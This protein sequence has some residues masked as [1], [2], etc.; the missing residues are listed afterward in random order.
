[1]NYLQTTAAIIIMR[2]EMILAVMGIDRSLDDFP[3]LATFSSMVDEKDLD[4]WA[5]M[6]GS[7][8]SEGYHKLLKL[9]D[10]DSVLRSLLDLSIAVFCYPETDAYFVRY[11]GHGV[12]LR[13]AFLMEGIVSPSEKD[14][15]DKAEKASGIFS[16]DDKAYPLSYAPVSIDEKTAFFL[17]GEKRINP[18][19][20][21]VTDY[22]SAGKEGA[23]VY[24]NEG[25]IEEGT[26]FF[27]EGGLYL[28]LSGKGGRRFIAKRIADDLNKDFLFINTGD[29]IKEAG[30]DLFR[31]Y[32]DCLIREAILDEAG[33][34]FFGID[35]P[36][37][38]LERTLF[39]PVSSK[40]IPIILCADCRRAVLK[41]KDKGEYRNLR[42]PDEL[43]LD[44]RKKLWEEL[45]KDKEYGLDPYELALKYRLN[46][47][48][49]ARVA[50]SF[51][52]MRG[53]GD[54]TEDPQELL[55]RVSIEE[56]S[57]GEEAGYGRVVY[58]DIRLQDV[59]VKD[60][61]K[62]TLNEVVTSVRTS[63][64]ILDKWGLKKT[65]PY[66]RSVSL[67]ISGPPGTGKTMTANAIAGELSLGLYQ[68]NLSNIIDKFI[69]ETEK[70]LEKVFSYAEKSN[71]VLFFDEADSLFGTRSEVH[72][73]KDRYA[74]TEISYLLQRIEA[75]E[76]IV[77]M[78]TNIKGNID[79]AFMRRI[80]YV[81]HFENPD[82]E[83]RKE[84]W[85][86]LFTGEVPHEE[87]DFQYL[88][89]QFDDFT[90][91]VIKTVF[92]NACA[93]AAGK[94]EALGMKH[95]VA[96]IGHELNKASAVGFSMDNLGKYAYLL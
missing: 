22:Y 66:G 54:S 53:N 48:E 90:G 47:S 24:V 40:G 27:R 71:T 70:N 88:A 39:L 38:F 37:E 61:I 16:F 11:F 85:M 1:M 52:E 74:N 51:L 13:L 83:M 18:E 42:L 92:L 10:G 46:A 67:L 80:R 65:Y 75:Y 49:T 63:A 41:L 12:N 3:F 8:E 35:K 9:L 30:K 43:S 72:D 45:L 4:K 50:M 29:F 82:E 34:C 56:L 20:R 84:I 77:I 68:V 33:V 25:L 96:A 57:E 55:T 14:I 95:L 81:V 28:Q 78:A 58:P 76:G 86:S 21:D 87:I 60:S 2:S 23:G 31:R 32:R 94:D 59:K 64:V 69:G 73:S 91:S 44:D 15:I 5:D 36:S 79:P 6:E 89:S 26:A 93:A 19:I 17:N 7:T 62:N